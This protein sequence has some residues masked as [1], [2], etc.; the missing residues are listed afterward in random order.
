MSRAMMGAGLLAALA[1]LAGCEVDSYMDPSVL[2][3]W[4]HTPTVVPILERLAPIEDQAGEFV[5]YS[6][7]GESDLLPVATIYRIGPGDRLRVTVYDVI[8]PGK[9]EVYDRIVDV[10]GMLELPQFGQVYLANMTFEEAKTALAAVVARLVPDPLV[11]IEALQQRQ[12]T[13]TI[14]GAVDQP[15]P[16]FIPDA[17]YRLLEALTAGGRFDNSV[18]FVYV[19]RQVKITDEQRGMKAP[20]IQPDPGQPT[21]EKFNELIDQ[22]TNPGTAPGG[23]P[24]GTPPAQPPAQPPV[25]PP[26]DLPDAP[27][28]GGGSPGL[29]QPAQPAIDIEPGRRD[30]QP[31]TA[32]TVGESG[33]VYING[34]WVQVGRGE[35]GTR[36]GGARGELVTQRIIRVPMEPLLAGKREYNIVIRPGDIL[37]VPPPPN[38]YVYLAGQV[39]R[40]GPYGIPTTGRYTFMRALVSAGGL[41]T[42]AIPERIDLTRIVGPD[43]QATIR[44]DG[45]AIAEGTQPDIVLKPDDIINVGTNFW[46]QPLAVIRNGFRASYGFGF[47]LDR[48]FS[49]E[50]FGLSPS[51]ELRIPAS[52]IP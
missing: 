19:I 6:E 50:V 32:P 31:R 41:G 18:P 29:L 17:D 14:L 37:R 12:Q 47:L 21:G 38:G 25:Q 39:A 4:E 22:M 51:Q 15:G 24:A 46:A 7:V 8:E 40:P 45:R 9:P 36:H 33:W 10:R 26:I 23:T 13:F 5:E 3:R 35:S 30:G 52:T 48:N 42:F 49:E 44:L 43:R 16:Y 1:G 11:S 27:K 2:G 28:S 34:K 20:E